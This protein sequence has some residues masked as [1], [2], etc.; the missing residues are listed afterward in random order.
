MLFTN[1]IAAADWEIFDGVGFFIEE[2]DTFAG[3]LNI[4]DVLNCVRI[5]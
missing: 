3:V 4:D 1:P 2:D 5:T